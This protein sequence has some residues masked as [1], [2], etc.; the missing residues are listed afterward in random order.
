[1]LVRLRYEIV[2]LPPLLP[3]DHAV[4]VLV[5]PVEEAAFEIL[6]GNVAV[7]V[8]GELAEV[9]EGSFLACSSLV[10]SQAENSS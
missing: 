7:L 3:V 4:L 8:P 10:N 9:D 1:M 6:F 2:E 5:G